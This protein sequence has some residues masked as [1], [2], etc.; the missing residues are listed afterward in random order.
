MGRMGWEVWLA[1]DLPG[2]YEESPPTILDELKRDQRW[3]QGNL[4]HLRLL[5]GEGIRAGHRAIMAMGV[6]AYA[7]A[8]LWTIFLF[9]STAEVAAASLIPPVYFSPAPSLFP[10]WPQW[11]PEVA[12]ALL[13]ATAVLLFLPKFLSFLLIV[14]KGE[15]FRYG[16]AFRLG[17]GVVIEILLSMLLA[18]IRMWFHTKFVL[19]TLMGRRIKWGSQCRDDTATG[20]KEALRRHGVSMVCGLVWTAALFWLNPA[21]AWWVLPVSVPMVFSAPL[22]VYS[23]RTGIGRALRRWRLLLIPEESSPTE[24]LERLR[25]ALDK[26]HARRGAPAGFVRV[27]KDAGLELP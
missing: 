2:S 13:S 11:H 24:A 18:P 19:L 10:F 17:L 9:L 27:A 23:S 20:W 26:R 21:L 7:S 6:M 5:F 1:Y 22:S 25:A 16:G 3:C 12:V 15:A 14:R 4:Q 8:F